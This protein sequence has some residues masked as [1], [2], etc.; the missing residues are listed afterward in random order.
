LGAGFGIGGVTGTTII[1]VNV[2]TGLGLSYLGLSL[3]QF[4]LGR[5]FKLYILGLGHATTGADLLG[6]GIFGFTVGAG[7]F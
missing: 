1:T 2:G 4:F 6:T 5:L 3:D 7:P